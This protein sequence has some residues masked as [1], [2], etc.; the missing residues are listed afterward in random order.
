MARQKQ[1]SVIAEVAAEVAAAS[2]GKPG[3]TIEEVSKKTTADGVEARSVSARIR[4]VDDLLRHIEADMSR[5][6]IVSSEATKWEGLTADKQTGEPVVTEL[7]RVHV[8][9]RP[10]A[11]PSVSECVEAMIAA[12]SKAIR[13]PLTKS[14]KGRRDGVWQVLPVADTHFGNYA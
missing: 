7:H 14:V 10:K 11:G 9:L 5:F 12:A 3:I 8:R 4:T 6:E 2:T 1:R 13:K